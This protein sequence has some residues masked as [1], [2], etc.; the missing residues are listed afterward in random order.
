MDSRFA[1]RLDARFASLFAAQLTLA[2]AVQLASI[3]AIASSESKPG[4][5]LL[6]VGYSHSEAVGLHSET[7]V[8]GAGSPYGGFFGTLADLGYL[9][10]D[11][12]VGGRILRHDVV[13]ANRTTTLAISLVEAGVAIRAPLVPLRSFEIEAIAGGG[14][15]WQVDRSFG[16]SCPFNNSLPAVTLGATTSLTAA[17]FWNATSG[18]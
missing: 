3:P 13:E 11:L 1:S 12:E 7:T 18:L 15:A 9:G 2:F 5:L 4:D 16:P 8:A 10:L 6:T 17:L 14:G